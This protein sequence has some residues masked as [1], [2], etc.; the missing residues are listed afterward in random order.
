MANQSSNKFDGLIDINRR[1]FL[2]GL[3]AG[4]ITGSSLPVEASANGSVEIAVSQSGQEVT[5]I[6]PITTDRSIEN[7]YRYD[8]IEGASA[9][10]PVNL[11][12]SGASKLFFYRQAGSNKISLVVIHDIPDNGS[13]G[14]VRFDF[15]PSGL[16]D[17]DG[18]VVKDDPGEG[19]SRTHADWAW[20]PCC[21][22]G[23]AYRGR[24]SDGVEVTIDPSFNNGIQRWDVLDSD[25]SEVA[26]LSMTDSVTLTV[27]GSA[28]PSDLGTLVDMK[29]ALADRIDDNAM[30]RVH[31]RARAEPALE[32]LVE[33][34]ESEEGPNRSEVIEAVQRMVAGERVTDVVL[35]G[36]GPGSSPH[37]NVDTNISKLTAKYAVNPILEVLFAAISLL[38]AA[39][40]IP[41]LRGVVDSLSRWL[42]NAV[43]DLAG[44]FSDTLE[45]LIR[46]RARDAGLAIFGEAERRTKQRGK[47]ISEEEFKK[48]RDAEGA[49]F[50]EDS[51]SVIFQ[52]MLFNEKRDWTGIETDPLDE[53]VDELIN[54]LDADDGLDLKGNTE[55][56]IDAVEERLAG[57]NDDYEEIDFELTDSL[58][59]LFLRHLGI[60]EGVLIAV[61]V[62]ASVTGILSAA[63][64]IAAA[65]AA[66]V[67]FGGGVLGSLIQWGVGAGGILEQRYSHQLVVQE[68]LEPTGGSQ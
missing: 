35:A 60:I 14:D 39:R 7:F 64:P 26:N 18:W 37:L 41:G 45:Q 66:L 29:L 38:K 23:G 2:K 33:V 58:F 16:P 20:A 32:E 40:A 50:I 5:T 46:S 65:G 59:A 24:F 19:Y 22:D 10:T 52:D 4:S 15:Q 27:G 61:A 6:S 12:E 44:I 25:G 11:R 31:D 63:A 55:Q 67:G 34:A 54:G 9:N 68:I 42:G 57:I 13:S 8:E 53:S 51:S 21:T 47:K 1:L 17:G 62:V 36:A 49:P 48:V 28:L 30:G 56:A 43:A 3:T